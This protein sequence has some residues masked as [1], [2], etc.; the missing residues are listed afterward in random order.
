MGNGL[1]AVSDGPAF[2][3]LPM[4]RADLVNLP[5]L[6]LQYVA[7]LAFSLNPPAHGQWPVGGF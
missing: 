2:G 3:A 5:I 7:F 4:C 6:F 1:S